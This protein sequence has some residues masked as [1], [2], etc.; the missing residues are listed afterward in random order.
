MLL[1]QSTTTEVN[2]N[3]QILAHI[4]AIVVNTQLLSIAASRCSVE[5]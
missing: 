2:S 5:G 4:S 1:Q 3:K